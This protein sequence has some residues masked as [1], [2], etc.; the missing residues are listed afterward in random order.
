[1]LSGLPE[2]RDKMNFGSGLLNNL[3]N[4][5]AQT[6]RLIQLGEWSAKPR[7]KINLKN[8]LLSTLG[9]WCIK[10]ARS[11]KFDK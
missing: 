2:L 8:S 7:E 1:M 5:S 4:W 11:N 9:T 3:G 10:T 6:A